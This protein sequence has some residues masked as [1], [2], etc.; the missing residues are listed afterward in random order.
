MASRNKKG[1]LHGIFKS[2]F[3]IS[4]FY[5]PS[6]EGMDIYYYLVLEDILFL[7][8]R[9]V[10]NTVLIIEDITPLTSSYMEKEYE[11][12]F[13]FL[14]EQTTI[15]V[16]VSLIG[17]LGAFRQTCMRMDA[18]L[19]EDDRFI[20]YPEPFYQKYKNYCGND[21]TRFGFF[22]LALNEDSFKEPSPNEKPIPV[23]IPPEPEEEKTGEP[24]EEILVEPKDLSVESTLL[25]DWAKEIKA[26]L[27]EE[28]EV[29]FIPQTSNAK[30]EDYQLQC[31]FVKGDE[32][33]F[34]VLAISFLSV[35]DDRSEIHISSHHIPPATVIWT[36]DIFRQLVTVVNTYKK[37]GLFFQVS[38]VVKLDS[39][40]YNMLLDLQ[41]HPTYNSGNR[42]VVNDEK[43]YQYANTSTTM[44][45]IPF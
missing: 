37:R 5:K 36:L 44:V 33:L 11:R 15:T 1:K 8:L 22:L 14:K 31:S 7:K 17:N 10:E 13:T 3:Q 45:Y 16:L 38:I 29:T 35:S 20:A 2:Q 6:M 21:A 18:P 34:I 12:L 9:F 26:Q 25:N 4:F 24:Q 30:R 28:V 40:L 42:I 32:E 41:F 39:I 19:I 23:E 27:K 43:K